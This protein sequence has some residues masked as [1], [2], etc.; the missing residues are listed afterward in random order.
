M[1]DNGAK[2]AYLRDLKASLI[3]A[4]SSPVLIDAYLEL[5]AHGWDAGYDLGLDHGFDIGKPIEDEFL[6]H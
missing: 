4:G 3:A 6:N 5:A 1:K 2:E